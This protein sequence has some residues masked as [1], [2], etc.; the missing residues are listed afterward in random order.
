MILP[1]ADCLR[2]LRSRR[3]SVAGM[4]RCYCHS[5][6]WADSQECSCW[7]AM[8]ACHCFVRRRQAHAETVVDRWLSFLPTTRRTQFPRVRGR[9]RVRNVRSEACFKLSRA[10]HQAIHPCLS[11]VVVHAARVMYVTSAAAA[12]AESWGTRSGH[13]SPSHRMFMPSTH[14]DFIGCFTDS[15]SPKAL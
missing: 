13:S 8:L 7:Q 9:G 6:R 5:S 10:H 3:C 1:C 2:A 14:I 12:C 15:P 4:R 11:F